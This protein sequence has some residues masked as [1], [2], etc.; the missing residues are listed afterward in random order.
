M[1]LQGLIVRAS[2]LRFTLSYISTGLIFAVKYH[3]VFVPWCFCYSQLYLELMDYIRSLSSNV[4]ALFNC[5]NTITVQT[6]KKTA[7]VQIPDCFTLLR[8]NTQRNLMVKIKHSYNNKKIN[9][10]LYLTIKRFWFI[11]TTNRNSFYCR[12][13]QDIYLMSLSIG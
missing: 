1:W 12:C 5:S 6:W 7:Y 8:I 4:L 13:R 3:V 11:I 9:L 2:S 10:N